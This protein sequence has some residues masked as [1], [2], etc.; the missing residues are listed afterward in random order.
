MT[1]CS[2]PRAL[3]G[4]TAATRSRTTGHRRA[5]TCAW[6]RW[7]AGGRRCLPRRGRRDTGRA[8]LTTLTASG[9]AWPK[10]P[11]LGSAPARLLRLLRA[12]LVWRWA[13]C[14]PRGAGPPGAQPL[15]RVLELVT[16]KGAYVTDFGHS[17]GGTA[18]KS[19]F[20]AWSKV[21]PRQRPSSPLMPPWGAPGGSGQR[22]L[23]RETPAP[24][25][26]PAAA[27]GPQLAASY[28][29][30]FTASDQ[31]GIYRDGSARGRAPRRSRAK[32]TPPLPPW[33][34][35][36]SSAPAPPQGASGGSVQLGTPRAR[37]SHW[38]GEA[39]ASDARATRPPKLPIPP[40]L[41]IQAPRSTAACS[42]TPSWT[43]CAARRR[44]TASRAARSPCSETR[45]FRSDQMR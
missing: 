8:L 2:A 41:T 25:A 28:A 33:Q 5:S 17:G 12:R 15:P 43:R 6:R 39:T 30:A 26:A 1:G 10:C 40:P 3:S 24:P 7:V 29:T 19:W 22:A 23:S 13:V 18:G 37:P 42:T 9:A 45:A 20:S 27:S 44:K 14:T 34:Q 35:R 16:S 21:P 31:P 32:V 11:A 38:V 4:S 36:P